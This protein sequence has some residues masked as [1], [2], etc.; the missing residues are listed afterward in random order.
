MALLRRGSS[1]ISDADFNSRL[2]REKAKN[3]AVTVS[4]A[5]NDPSDLDLH[6]CIILDAGGKAIIDYN[7]KQG[8]GGYLDVD[9]HCRDEEVSDEPV[10]NIFWKKP[11]AGVYSIEVNLYKKRGRREDKE[12]VP[13]RAL[14]KRDDEEDISREGIVYFDSSFGSRRVEVFRF[15]VDEQ[16]EISIGKVGLPLPA[17]KPAPEISRPMTAIK[18]MKAMKVVMKKASKAMKVKKVMKKVTR[19]ASIIAKGKK[20]RVQVWRGKKVK[21]TGGLK[22]DQL[23]KSRKK[24]IV[25]KKRSEKGRESKWSRATQKAYKV[26]GYSGF[27]PIKKGTS[28]YEKAKEVMKDM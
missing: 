26:K 24:K 15:T 11:P 3:G 19:K 21:T 4:L 7:H 18:A 12:G 13:F 23:V 1:K 6:A 25:S 14:L 28:F 10:E 9:M 27:K 2:V 20:A 22:K 5:W 16:G 17:A 8:A